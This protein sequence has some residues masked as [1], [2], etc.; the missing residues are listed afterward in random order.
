MEVLKKEVSE[1][2]A[3]LAKRKTQIDVE[4]ADVEPLVQAAKAAIGTIKSENLAEIRALRAPPDVIRDILEGAYNIFC[5]FHSQ[6]A[7][8]IILTLYFKRNSIPF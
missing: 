3:K 6:M 8:L 2:N 5:Q 4:L 7:H 1:E